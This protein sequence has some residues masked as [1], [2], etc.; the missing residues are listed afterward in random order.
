[1]SKKKNAYWLLVLAVVLI[2]TAMILGIVR[3]SAHYYSNATKDVLIDTARIEGVES[4]F[5][6]EGGQT[7]LMGMLEDIETIEIDVC[8]ERNKEITFHTEFEVDSGINATIDQTLTL[9]GEKQTLDLVFTDNRKTASEAKTVTA[10]IK[11][12]VDGK[13]YT[14]DFRMDLPAIEGDTTGGEGTGNENTG[15]N[16]NPGENET[17]GD[18]TGGENTGDG[19]TEGDGTGN[20]NTE[21]DNDSTGSEN[22]NNGTTGEVGG[23][24]VEEGGEFS[25]RTVTLAAAVPEPAAVET[26][27]SIHTLTKY[28]DGYLIPVIISA[29]GSG[30]LTYK[31]VN[32]SETNGCFPAYTRYSIDNGANWFMLYEPGVIAAAD[33]TKI[34]LID[35]TY[36]A[37]DEAGV[38]LSFT[39]DAGSSA[40][41]SLTR[42][43]EISLTTTAPVLGEKSVLQFVFPT[44]WKD[45]AM[46]YELYKL[47]VTAEGTTGFVKIE[48]EDETA[49]GVTLYDEGVSMHMVTLACG[50]KSVEAGTYQLIV[51]HQFGT[52]DSK[53]VFGKTVIPFFMVYD[54]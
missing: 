31:A 40:S 53:Y 30:T 24:G 49:P 52:T 43:G 22:E 16:E 8:G 23:E 27:V 25:L 36:A 42:G 29:E 51:T 18:T 11:C 35:P 19:T 48:A 32:S 12:S 41:A 44:D 14:A 33:G 37:W 50:G 2:T 46:E 20:G 5:F 26:A 3:A 47:E 9:N 28:Y 45:C 21:T 54:M 7:I 13:E 1:M 34:V 39:C 10:T 38:T 6:K 17:G 15:G 4:K